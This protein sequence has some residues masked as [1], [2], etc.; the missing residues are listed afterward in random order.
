MSDVIQFLLNGRAVSL[1]E[2]DPTTTLLDWLRLNPALRGTKEGCA[3]GDCGA[4]TV[5]L[6]RLTPVGAVERRA[7]TSCILMLGQ[8]HGSGVRTVE[9][10]GDPG[11]P[12]RHLQQAMADG[13][14]TQC[15]FCTPG[16]I[17]AGH[18][19][20]HDNAAPST[21]EIHDAIAG[22]LCRCTG[23]RPI[24][25]AIRASAIAVQRDHRVL[26][27]AAGENRRV[28]G[29]CDAALARSLE[30][31]KAAASG[32]RTFLSTGRIFHAPEDLD[33]ALRLR[34]TRPHAIML[35]GGT[36]LGPLVGRDR[37]PPAEI[38]SLSGVRDLTSVQDTQQGL[39][40]GAAVTYRDA[41]AALLGSWPELAEYLARLGSA[42]IRALGTIGGNLGT[43][44]P[45]GDMLPVLIALDA[46]VLT[47]TEHG[48]R[49]MDVADFLTGYHRNALAADEIITGI[50]LPARQPGTLVFAD[51]L[52]RRRDQDIS[53]VT[54]AFRLRLDGDRV[55]DVRIAFGGM[56]DRP[57][58]AM[59]VE[60]ELA[61]KVWSP[62][63][64]RQAA[65]VVR[66]TFT[67]RDD[68]RAPAL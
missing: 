42:Q 51:K 8:I 20:L 46:E 19:L 13:G 57:V 1:V 56:A 3:E 9:G 34:A 38:I 2:I 45:I 44:S 16:F 40:I 10:V 7:V 49:R 4:C 43:A 48:R 5:T 17:M 55:A 62:Q 14:G 26:V 63:V 25:D 68:L 18:A 24:V 27:D 11:T 47:A 52:S 65:A 36:D 23:Y 58:R 60:A 35:A 67:P 50:A 54:A 29:P 64:L 6:E 61:G 33:A 21:H 37:T 32:R 41:T 30:T 39:L 31:L 15:G 22:N 12:G 53:S 59:A 28:V 66:T